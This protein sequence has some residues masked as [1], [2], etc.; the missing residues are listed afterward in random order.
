[1]SIVLKSEGGIH[2]LALSTFPA[3]ELFLKIVGFA[4]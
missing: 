3:G 1:M 2:E 4:R